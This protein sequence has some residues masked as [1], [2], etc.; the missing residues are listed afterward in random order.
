MLFIGP[1]KWNKLEGDLLLVED[2]AN[3]LSAGSDGVSVQLENHDELKNV[4]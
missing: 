3:A 4:E 2:Y 1:I